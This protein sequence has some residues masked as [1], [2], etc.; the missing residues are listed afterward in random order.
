MSPCAIIIYLDALKDSSF[1]F[2]PSLELIPRNQL[3][4][5]SVKKSLCD[6]MV[7]T[8]PLATHAPDELVLGLYRLK[9]IV[10]ILA[11]PGPN[12]R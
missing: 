8:V 2:I 11:C 12:D 9:I 5:E 3:D 6:G 1:C 7:P 4:L 10:G